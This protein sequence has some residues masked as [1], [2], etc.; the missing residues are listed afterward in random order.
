MSC[1][2]ITLLGITCSILGLTCILNTLAI[3]NL[4][5]SINLLRDDK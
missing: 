4:S 5:K 3:R 2:N 1:L